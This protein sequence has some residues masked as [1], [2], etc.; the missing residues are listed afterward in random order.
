MSIHLPVPRKPTKS[1]LR[2]ERDKKANDWW[3]EHMKTSPDILADPVVYATFREQAL[4]TYNKMREQHR[5]S[6]R[7][8]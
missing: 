5:L 4:I 2:K 3:L 6:A 7:R 8:P 1:E